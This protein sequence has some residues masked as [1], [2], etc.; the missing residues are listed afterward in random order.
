ML[1]ANG[2]SK[3]VIIEMQNRRPEMYPVPRRRF[4]PVHH[5]PVFVAPGPPVYVVPAC[6]PPPPAF[7]VGV[8][9]R[10]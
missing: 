3:N 10:N 2:V 1:G 9:I 5:G 7:G 6:P 8:H 4:V